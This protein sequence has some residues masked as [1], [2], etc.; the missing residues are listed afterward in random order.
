MGKELAPQYE[1]RGLDPSSQVKPGGCG[2]L[3]AIPM[4]RR[5]GC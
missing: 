3:P 2:N 5:R 4:L 1:G